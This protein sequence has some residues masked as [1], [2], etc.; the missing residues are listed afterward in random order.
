MEELS[1]VCSNAISASSPRRLLQPWQEIEYLPI[2]ARFWTAPVLWRFQI[3][4]WLRL[5]KR[6]RTG[7]V[8]NADAIS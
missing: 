5:Q 7:A 3:E 8:Q 4:Q 2:S 1:R 6:Q